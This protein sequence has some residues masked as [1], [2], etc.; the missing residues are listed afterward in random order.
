[1]I[2]ILLAFDNFEYSGIRLM[3]LL[4][5]ESNM[6]EELF[7][8]ENYDWMAHRE[9]VNRFAPLAMEAEETVS[10]MWEDFFTPS[11][12]RASRCQWGLPYGVPPLPLQ[13]PPPR[14]RRKNPEIFHRLLTPY[15]E[16]NV[17]EGVKQPKKRLPAK[18]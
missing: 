15:P 1:M 2:K 18:G 17:T 6:L 13:T 3:L 4:E 10:L 5:A 14:S 9:T 12:L 11:S 8:S 7:T 16:V